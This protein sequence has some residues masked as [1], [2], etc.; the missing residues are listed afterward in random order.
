MP[1]HSRAEK[2][3]ASLHKAEGRQLEHFLK[4]RSAELDK[5]IS[6]L[7]GKL[8][9]SNMNMGVTGRG[10]TALDILPAGNQKTSQQPMNFTHEN[11]SK[12]QGEPS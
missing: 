4:D 11:S 10:L 2:F 3:S 9:T 6:A 7:K 1:S 8:G 5:E 12:T